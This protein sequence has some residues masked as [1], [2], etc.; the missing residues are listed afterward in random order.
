MGRHFSGSLAN[1]SIA[2]G[3]GGLGTFS[4][5]F[6][7]TAMWINRAS[8]PTNWAT[9]VATNLGSGAC[10]DLEL[11]SAG[12]FDYWDGSNDRTTSTG[13]PG[14]GVTALIGTTKGTG[15]VAGRAHSWIPTTGV[16]SHSALSGTS[17]NG[18]AVTSLTYGAD[19]TT[20]AVGSG[21]YD[22]DIFEL[23]MWSSLAMSDQEWE[24]LARWKDW[25]R[26]APDV[27]IR[28]S[29]GRDGLNNVQRTMGRQRLRQTT[30][31]T[32]TTRSTTTPPPGFGSS[33]FRR[34]S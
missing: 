26:F 4:F 13:Y 12:N 8:T 34:R 21:P 20:S 5:A 30:S 28:E 7:T 3:T 2:F 33:V 17:V 16:M 11:T 27:W 29:D 25:S 6:G 14:N 19:R 15:T 22:G 24:R 32:G 18:A 9:P 23:A 10:Y 1:Q 31:G